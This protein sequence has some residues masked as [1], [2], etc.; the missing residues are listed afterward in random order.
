MEIHLTLKAST[1]AALFVL[2]LNNSFVKG[3]K[4]IVGVDDK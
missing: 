4:A 3:W 2:R 1:P